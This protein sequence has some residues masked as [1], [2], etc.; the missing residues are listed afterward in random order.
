MCLFHLSFIYYFNRE[1]YYLCQKGCDII[2]QSSI[3]LLVFAILFIACSFLF[4]KHSKKR[5]VSAIAVI[6]IYV[7]ASIT[8]ILLLVSFILIIAEKITN[9][10]F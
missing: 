4:M 2:L 3:Q 10:P 7:I 5:S 9:L 6:L 8:V 1:I